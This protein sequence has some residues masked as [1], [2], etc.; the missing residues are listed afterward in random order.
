MLENTLNDVVKMMVEMILKEGEGD[1]HERA[2]IICQF[3]NRYAREILVKM[4]LD[5]DEA[6]D[7]KLIA[8]D[9]E[10]PFLH[11]IFELGPQNAIRGL[12]L[13]NVNPKLTEIEHP[14]NKECLAFCQGRVI[15][16]DLD[17]LDEVVVKEIMSYESAA[18]FVILWLMGK[19]LEIIRVNRCS[20][21]Q[22]VT[23]LYGR[24]ETFFA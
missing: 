2:K 4:G 7:G 13:F 24:L 1:W 15:N 22:D 8:E 19:T 20:K 16:F 9:N 21:L 17:D 3:A 14:S 11:P 12:F 6:I 5:V 23:N 10:P 18:E